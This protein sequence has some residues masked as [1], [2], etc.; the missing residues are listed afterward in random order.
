ML[1]G[2]FRVICAGIWARARA[3][4][5]DVQVTKFR[6]NPFERIHKLGL[7][8]RIDVFVLGRRAVAEERLG[9]GIDV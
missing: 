7:R 2:V 9:I 1:T 5:L 3:L 6:G 8:R 4:F